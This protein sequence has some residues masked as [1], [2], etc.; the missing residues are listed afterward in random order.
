MIYTITLKPTAEGPPPAIRLRR[1]LKIAG[2]SLGL[3]CVSVSEASEDPVELH[4]NTQERRGGIGMTMKTTPPHGAP[5]C[6]PLPL[7][8]EDGRPVPNALWMK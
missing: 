4:Q 7:V 1:L 3:R 5:R 6:E 8:D 2:R